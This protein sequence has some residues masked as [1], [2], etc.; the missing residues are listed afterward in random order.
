MFRKLFT[1]ESVSVGH[2]DVVASTIADAILDAFMQQDKETRAGIEVSCAPDFVLVF[3]EIRTIAEVNIEEIVRNTVAKIGYDS[4]SYG[5]NA[6]TL[7]VENRLHLQSPDIAQGVDKDNE[8]VGAGD[9]G[10][11]FG[12]AC[13]ETDVLYPLTAQLANN[14]MRVYTKFFNENKEDYSPD[15]KSQVT[16]DYTNGLIDTIIVAASHKEHV[17]ND[18]IYSDILTN[19]VM[20]ALKMTKITKAFAESIGHPEAETAADLVPTTGFNFYVNTTGKFVICGPYGDAGVNGRKLTVDS[21]GGHAKIG[22]GNT[23]GKC[24]SKTD[25]NQAVATRYVAKNLVAAGIADKVEIQVSSA[26]GHVE[27]VSIF[28]DTFGTSK[29]NLTDEEIAEKVYALFNFSV[30]K[31]IETLDLK[32]VNREKTNFNYTFGV[33][34][35]E[36]ACKCSCSLKKVHTWEQLDLVDSL[37][38]SFGL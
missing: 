32:N 26:I 38:E 13:N 1:S 8:E 18:Q 29:V 24:V 34:A 3:G 28:V 23:H 21:Y 11:M 33:S 37:K 15:A 19:V 10:I 2:P 27:P 35:E 20:P 16:F 12:F 4:D 14:I 5:F 36:C 31:V 17:T 7:V 30:H 25:F 9:Q 22:G 6:N